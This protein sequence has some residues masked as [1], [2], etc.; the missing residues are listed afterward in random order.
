MPQDKWD[1]YINL[2]YSA[3]NIVLLEGSKTTPR[4]IE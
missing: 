3:K 1:L 4:K 2:L